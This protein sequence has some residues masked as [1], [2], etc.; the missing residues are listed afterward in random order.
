MKAEV[1]KPGTNFVQVTPAHRKKINS[2]VKFYRNKPHPF[3]A[4]VR[5]NRKRF[6][7][8]TEQVCAVVKDMALG[9]TKWRKGGKKHLS[10]AGV[11]S[12][13]DLSVA[14]SGLIELADL[15]PDEPTVIDLATWDGR[16]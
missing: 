10:S 2:I 6:G 12:T 13:V 11:P 7:N 16:L 4:C 14:L 8:R 1:G 5:D 3:A 15:L 9:T